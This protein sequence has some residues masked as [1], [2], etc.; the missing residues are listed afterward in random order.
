[1]W[2]SGGVDKQKWYRF[3]FKPGQ[4]IEAVRDDEGRSQGTLLLEVLAHQGTDP[5]GHWLTGKYVVASDSHMRWWMSEG[6]GRVLAKKGSFH[7]CEENAKRRGR[8]KARLCTLRSSA[9]SPRRRCPA[10]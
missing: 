4:L 5:K 6:E 3:K 9:R 1:M 8:A 2:L 10:G 7:F